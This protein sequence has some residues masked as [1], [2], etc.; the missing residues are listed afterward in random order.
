MYTVSVTVDLTW[1]SIDVGQRRAQV[2]KPQAHKLSIGL[3]YSFAR[4]LLSCGN[5][6]DESLD[7]K[8]YILCS[9]R[10]IMPFR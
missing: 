3:D 4:L 2:K 5:I 7:W 6:L 8:K 1:H 10:A 9:L